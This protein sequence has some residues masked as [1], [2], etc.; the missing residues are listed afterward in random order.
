MKRRRRIILAVAALALV[1][2]LALALMPRAVPVELTRVGRGDFEVVVEA[3]G[4]ARVRARY[5]VLAPVSGELER[6]ALDPGDAVRKGEPV[7]RIAASAAP[8]L[9]PRR[10]AEAEGELQAST[11]AKREAEAA[12]VQAW[13]ANAQAQRD[14]ERTRELAERGAA[15]ER[16]LEV[17]RT[18]ARQRRNEVVAAEQAV[19]RADARIEAARAVLDPPEEGGHA[20][21]IEAPVGGKVLR[22]L[23]ES[24][25]PVEIGAPLLEMGDPRRLEVVLDVLTTQAVEID[26][27]D[28]VDLVQWGG[29]GALEGVVERVDPSAETKVSA[30]GV[31]EQRVNVIVVPAEG[32]DWEPLSDGYHV[33]AR[34]ITRVVEDALFVPTTALFRRDG[35]WA[36]FVV[37]D[38]RA[39]L[40]EVEVGATSGGQAQI[41]S[42]LAGRERVIVYPSDEVSEGTRVT[43][44]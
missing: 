19:E 1:V 38:G 39:R 32:Q 24:G 6:I 34:I 21:A 26:P 16:E 5:S 41:T 17:A 37:E 14:L 13:A 40:R 11:A 30:L 4:E 33:E 31:E 9:N 8:P 22:V 15:T 2:L 7:A 3:D 29:E 10:R 25:G 20:V 36:L 27:G 42:G 43:A 28:K 35:Q 12:L 44:Q 18:E 23:R